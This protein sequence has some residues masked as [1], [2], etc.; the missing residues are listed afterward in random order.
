[1]VKT[2]FVWEEKP[3]CWRFFEKYSAVELEEI[4]PVVA[5]FAMRGIEPYD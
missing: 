2:A 5:A 1:V 3:T 4:F